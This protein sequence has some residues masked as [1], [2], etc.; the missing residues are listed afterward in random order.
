MEDDNEHCAVLG[1]G[2]M[3]KGYYVTVMSTGPYEKFRFWLM[4]IPISS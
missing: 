3:H 2:T 4:E 1:G